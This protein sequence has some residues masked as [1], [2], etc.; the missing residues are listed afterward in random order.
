MPEASF[1]IFGAGPVNPELQVQSFSS[2]LASGEKE[3]ARHSWQT[4]EVAPT[5]VEYWPETHLMHTAL[6][7]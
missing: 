4:L 7:R 1:R 5:A 2:L 6:P 3:F